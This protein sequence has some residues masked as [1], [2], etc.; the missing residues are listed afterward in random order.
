MLKT[1]QCEILILASF[2]RLHEFHALGK[3][4]AYISQPLVSHCRAHEHQQRHH[5]L[6]LEERLHELFLDVH[7]IAVEASDINEPHLAGWLHS[8]LVSA[9]DRY[10]RLV[11]NRKR[12]RLLKIAVF[13]QEIGHQWTCEHVLEKIAS[14]YEG[15]NLPDFFPQW[16][17][18]L[19][20]S[21]HS[22]SCVLRDCWNDTVGGVDI[23]P[24]LHLSPLHAAV[25][26]CEPRIIEAIFLR[27]NQARV[28]IEERDLNGRTALFAAVANGDESCCRALLE[29][30]ADAKTRD[31]CGRTALEV[32]V[33]RGSLN[34]VKCLIE[35]HADVN[36]N[37]MR[38]SALPLHVAIESMPFNYDIISHLLNSGAD[39]LLPRFAGRYTDGK[40]AIDLADDRGQPVLAQKM[41]DMVAGSTTFLNYFPTSQF[42]HGPDLLLD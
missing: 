1:A 17:E 28:D 27:P 10:P 3:T 5:D 9:L 40:N 38:C 31:N 4:L 11:D 33:S 20:I 14:T 39:V 32:A 25:Q 22:I 6:P 29:Y 7:R 21:S 8:E 37:H 35:H 36:P 15:S 34:I 2:V 13:F 16:A 18:S 19:S 24:N 41:R 30:G 23:D 42:P 12:Y 26:H